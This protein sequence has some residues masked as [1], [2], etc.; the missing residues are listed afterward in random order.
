M[1]VLI[2]L[3]KLCVSDRL[4]IYTDISWNIY[5]NL[6]NYLGNLPDFKVIYNQ[7]TLQIISPSSRH[8]IYKKMLGILVGNYCL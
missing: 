4:L 7:G 6:L 5:E 2:A 3:A 8:E 1:T